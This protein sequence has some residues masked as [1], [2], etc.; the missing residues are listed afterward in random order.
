MVKIVVLGAGVIGVASAVKIKEKYKDCEVVLMSSEF[1]PNTTGDGSGG[2]WYPYLCGDTPTKLIEKWGIETYEFLQE[3]WRTAGIGVCMMPIYS[4]YRNKESFSR[5]G[6]KDMVQ[7]YHE[8]NDKQLEFYNRMYS[9]KYA[10]GLTFKTFVISP[11]ALLTYLTKRFEHAGGTLVQ[12]KLTSLQ[13]PILDGFDVVV[14]CTGLGARV[15]VPDDR[16]VPVRGQI[17]KVKAPWI[18]EAVIDHE[19]GNYL[20]PNADT[21]VLGGTHQNDFSTEIF[22]EDTEFIMAGCKKMMPGLE[23]A[24]LV[25]HWAGLRPGRDAIRLEPEHKN[26]KLYIH[27]YGHGGSGFTLCWGCGEEVLQILQKELNKNK[28]LCRN[29]K[30]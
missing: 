1:S 13:D 10:A 18:K 4:F 25:S 30:L 14:N 7:E 15:L 23:H 11:P 17:A 8:L 26:G 27:N 2:L 12:A 24:E 5:P 6:W 19:G 9:A 20:I 21:C 3:L 22:P 28:R 29:S 16:V